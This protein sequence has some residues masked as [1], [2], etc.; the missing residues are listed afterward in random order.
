[1]EK[2]KIEKLYNSKIKEFVRLNKLY[3][4]NSE[5][6]VEDHVYDQLKKE[7][8]LQMAQQQNLVS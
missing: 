1:M 4:D 6:G 8:L 7:I 5:P 3:Y 2:Q